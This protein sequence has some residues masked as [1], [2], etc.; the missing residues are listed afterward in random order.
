MSA[1]VEL[2]TISLS[3]VDGQQGESAGELIDLLR[4]DS[5]LV[6]VRQLRE[7]GLGALRSELVQL[8]DSG[9]DV[10]GG[11][12]SGSSAFGHACT[13]SAVIA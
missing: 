13:L 12:K 4:E 10:A 9:G 2:H 6:G 3:D 5:H 11:L 8:S 1:S 7:R